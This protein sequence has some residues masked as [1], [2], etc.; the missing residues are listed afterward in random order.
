[1]LASDVSPPA[2]LVSGSGAYL[3]GTGDVL[4]VFVWNQPELSTTVPVRPDGRISTPLVEDVVAVGKTPSQ[5]A[6]D[7]EEVLSEF[8]RSPTVNVIVQGFQGVPGA[9]I[10]VLGQAQ[11]PQEIPYREGMTLMDALITAGGLTEFASG[12]RSRLVR[13]IDG[14]SQEIRVRLDRLM[15][16]GRLEENVVLQPGD[17]IIIPETIF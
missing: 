1:M 6:R 10:R 14:E 3:I 16:E 8:V 17:V 12:D 15:N 9:Q 2:P 5:L 7:M 13:T 11:Q 4:E